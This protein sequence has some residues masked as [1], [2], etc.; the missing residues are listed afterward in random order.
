MNRS[1]Y[2]LLR[3]LLH[4]MSYF[5][6][7]LVFGDI[8]A[9]HVLWGWIKFWW[10]AIINYMHYVAKFNILDEAVSSSHIMYALV[11][12]QKKSNNSGQNSTDTCLNTL[13]MNKFNVHA[14]STAQTFQNF[15][16]TIATRIHFYLKFSTKTWYFHNSFVQISVLLKW[17]AIYHIRILTS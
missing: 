2:R 3:L 4:F 11:L 8:Q 14:S 7:T 1:S 12:L 5:N 15:G 17:C 16:L 6:K 13:L 9:L 10:Y